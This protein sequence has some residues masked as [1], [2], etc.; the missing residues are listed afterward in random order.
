MLHINDNTIATATRVIKQHFTWSKDKLAKL[1]YIYQMVCFNCCAHIPADG[2]YGYDSIVVCAGGCGATF[3]S[4]YCVE[5]FAKESSQT[6][7]IDC[8]VI[9]ETDATF[10]NDVRCSCASTKRGTDDVICRHHDNCRRLVECYQQHVLIDACAI[11]PAQVLLECWIMLTIPVYDS[12]NDDARANMVICVALL[13]SAVWMY[14]VSNDL[15]STALYFAN[16]ANSRDVFASA[17]IKLAKNQFLMGNNN[18]AGNMIQRVLQCSVD[19]FNFDALLLKL[20]CTLSCPEEKII[21]EVSRHAAAT[22]I[23][24]SERTLHYDIWNLCYAIQR[25]DFYNMQNTFVSIGEFL[26]SEV[27]LSYSIP[28]ELFFALHLLKNRIETC[29]TIVDDRV[30][31]DRF[32]NFYVTLGNKLLDKMP[33]SAY[34]SLILHAEFFYYRAHFCYYINADRETIINNCIESAAHFKAQF[35]ENRRLYTRQIASLQ[36]LLTK[37]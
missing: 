20:Y 18:L 33:V 7:A 2:E 29:D 19:A 11:T 22:P 36:D 16:R 24:V 15:L 23:A 13:M 9:C 6:H 5:E 35:G 32:K 27:P 31:T 4:L 17:L 8:K 34:T 25:N 14:T 1:Q 21:S 28:R 3:C 26:D 30:I 12:I 37:I 10:R